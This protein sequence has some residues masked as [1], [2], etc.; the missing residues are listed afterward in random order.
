MKMY[1]KVIGS[2]VAM[3][4]DFALGVPEKMILTGRLVDNL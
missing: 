2:F 4:P 3:V 1:V